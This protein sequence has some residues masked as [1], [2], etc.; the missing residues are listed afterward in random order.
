MKAKLG[1]STIRKSTRN[2]R[3]NVTL[4]GNNNIET[5]F[6]VFVA[7]Q[8]NSGFEPCLDTKTIVEPDIGGQWLQ[9]L[10]LCLGCNKIIN[11]VTLEII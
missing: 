5:R 1:W 6:N 3:L 7:T 11:Q 8:H 9:E 10:V 4:W 2:T